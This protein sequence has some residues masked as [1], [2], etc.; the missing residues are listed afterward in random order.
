M[1]LEQRWWLSPRQH[2][3]SAASCEVADLVALTPLSTFCPAV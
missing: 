3:S 2:I 1:G